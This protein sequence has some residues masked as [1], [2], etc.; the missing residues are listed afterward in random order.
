MA[1]L[2][3]TAAV[4][5][6]AEITPE[7]V[8]A[9][10]ATALILDVDNTLALHGSPKPFEGTV[11][12]VQYMREKGIRMII[13]SNNSRQRVAPFAAQYGLPFLHCACKPFPFAYHA[14]ARRLGVRPRD[15]VVV[16]DQ[17]FTDIVGA[18]LAL[19]KSILLTPLDITPA[20]GETSRSFAVRRRLEQPVRRRIAR[21][22]RGGEYFK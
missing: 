20:G 2:L 14:A 3:P 1:F 7:L 22:G 12:W 5:R 15:A 16:G 11:E 17:V 10:R 19:M 13:L 18:N 4:K 6:A 21:S 8:R 9:M